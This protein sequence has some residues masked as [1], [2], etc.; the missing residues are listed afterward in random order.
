MRIAA[1][2]RFPERGS[3]VLAEAL[4]LPG[5]RLEVLLLEELAVLEK[6]G[7]HMVGL[8]KDDPDRG[9]KGHVSWGGF[10]A[11]GRG[12][13]PAWRRKSGTRVLRYTSLT[14]LCRA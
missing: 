9:R 5:D 1:C 10:G 2:F 6:G 8:G 7:I 3:E 4:D 11:L 13:R 14:F 12:R